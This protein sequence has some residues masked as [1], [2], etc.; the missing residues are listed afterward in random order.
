M[1]GGGTGGHLAI[2]KAVKEQINSDKLIYIG[3]SMGQDRAW[4]GD[5]NQFSEKYF[6]NTRGVVNQGLLGKV[7]SLWLLSKATTQAYKILKKC[8]AKVV[9]CVG[10]FSAAPTSIAALIARIPLVVHEQNAALGS[11]N[12]ILRKYASAFISSYEENSPIKSRVFQ[13]SQT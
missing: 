2:I 8:D 4:F 6:M 13:Y 3:S 7:K 1:T 12:K 5:D 11:L 10:G 9:F